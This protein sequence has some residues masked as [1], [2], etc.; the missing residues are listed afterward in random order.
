MDI[1]ELELSYKDVSISLLDFIIVKPEYKQERTIVNMIKIIKLLFLVL[2]IYA[3]AFF[4]TFL[5]TPLYL[6]N[7]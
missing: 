2:V 7:P 1:E 3:S 5:T 4:I 6:L